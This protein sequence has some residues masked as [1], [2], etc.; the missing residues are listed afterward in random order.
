MIEQHREFHA[1]P[2][3]RVLEFRSGGLASVLPLQAFLAE[4]LTVHEFGLDKA[5]ADFLRERDRALA[6]TDPPIDLRTG[7]PLD[8]AGACP[9]GPASP[10]RFPPSCGGHTPRTA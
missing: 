6:E 2:R 1:Y 7:S 8:L 3:F 10:G 4:W 9:V 5:F